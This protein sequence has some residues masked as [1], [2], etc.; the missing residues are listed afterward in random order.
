MKSIFAALGLLLMVSGA[1][2]SQMNSVPSLV[3]QLDAALVKFHAVVIKRA[4]TARELFENYYM[5]L[6]KSDKVD[7][8]FEY[9]DTGAGLQ[10][11][12]GSGMGQ[13]NLKQAS[14]FASETIY[15]QLAVDDQG[16]E[17]SKSK[18]S[19]QDK[20]VAELL[21]VLHQAGAIF[22]FDNNGSAICGVSY[23]T[24]LV[25]DPATGTFYEFVFVNGPC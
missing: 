4:P 8:D 6:T 25:I 12:D 21:Q 2:A 22:G 19:A 24:L 16:N 9:S 5:K 17:I 1:Q 13:L 14:D 3:K 11:S 10:G 23:A 15:N 7:E 20:Q 18:L